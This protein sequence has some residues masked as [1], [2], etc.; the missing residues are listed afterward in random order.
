MADLIVFRDL[1][2]IAD[3]EQRLHDR[4]ENRLMKPEIEQLSVDI[5]RM[6]LRLFGVTGGQ[7]EYE[8]QPHV[9]RPFYPEDW[10]QHFAFL[11]DLWEEEL[12]YWEAAGLDM[13][14]GE[15]EPLLCVDVFGRQIICAILGIHRSAA[16]LFAPDAHNPAQVEA[17]A[18]AWGRSLLG[19]T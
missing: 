12:A 13:S 11:D 1:P 8:A 3:I 2:G 10:E 18:E 5:D 7:T 6:S 9:D 14:D 19:K 4:Y 15:G 17:A 16:L